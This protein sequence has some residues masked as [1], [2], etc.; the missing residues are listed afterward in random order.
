LQNNLIILI[1]K[2]I[3][4]DVKWQKRVLTFAEQREGKFKKSAFE[5]VRTGRKIADEIKAEFFKP[6]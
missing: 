1:L 4:R 6:L 2:Q 5:A 3:Q